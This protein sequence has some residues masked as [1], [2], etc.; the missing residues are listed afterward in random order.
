VEI[1]AE[2]RIGL[3]GGVVVCQAREVSFCRDVAG[4]GSSGGGGYPEK[5]HSDL[6]R[7]GR[8]K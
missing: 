7:D 6:L 4:V 5:D 3:P 1:E 2:E 8:S